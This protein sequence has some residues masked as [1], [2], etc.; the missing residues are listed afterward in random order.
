M[1][2][3]KNECYDFA[4]GLSTID[5]LGNPNTV[6][7]LE[8]PHPDS[9]K[10]SV[11]IL[12]AAKEREISIFPYSIKNYLSEVKEGDNLT[13]P[14][15]IATAIQ[16]ASTILYLEGADEYPMPYL[17]ME[18][19]RRAVTSKAFLHCVPLEDKVNLTEAPLTL[20]IDPEIRD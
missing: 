5:G 4:W 7:L 17:K 15:E 3:T 10:A 1:I 8:D 6:L 9:K 14:I 11:A 19:L 13:F 12:A 16:D 2:A 18:I 20:F